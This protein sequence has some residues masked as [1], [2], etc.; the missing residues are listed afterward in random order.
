MLP[1][2]IDTATAVTGAMDS[3]EKASESSILLC[4]PLELRRQIY[5]YSLL[6]TQNP[7]TKTIYLN[8]MPIN[9]RDHP[10]PLLL[11][12][13]QV[14]DE[15]IELVQTYPI[16]LRVTHQGVHF[17][18]LAETCFIAQQRSR[19]YSRIS[20]LCVHIW[21]PHLDRPIDIL[22]IWRHL[23]KLRTELRNMPLLKEVSFFFKETDMTT[24]TI[25]GKP[26]NL[27][28][29]NIEF[30]QGLG[31]DDITT[32]M[33]LFARVRVAKATFHMP[34]GLAPGQTTE[35]V[36]DFL[37]STNAMMMGR[38]S[39]DEDV[40]NDE[41]EEDVSWQNEVEEYLERD[42]GY[43]GACIARDKLDA[44]TNK[45]KAYLNY[46]EWCDFIEMWYPDFE[47][48]Y[49]EELKDEDDWMDHY[50]GERPFSPALSW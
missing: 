23:R 20:H 10:S 17:D 50:V 8:R 48:L 31:E 2:G 30:V 6:S 22:H 11:V 33:D 29:S 43:K 21:P 40:F 35:F 13:G 16:S 24:W 18:G 25:D 44:R 9:W 47:A 14:R 45:G 39:I 7:S 3:K 15:V 34:H 26:L 28:N 27:L 38:I 4:L 46:S 32:I 37:Q 49:G 5:R 19:D 1:A 12:N 41:D 36:G 42:L